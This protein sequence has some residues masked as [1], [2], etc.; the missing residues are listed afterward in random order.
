MSVARS[1]INIYFLSGKK[2][3]GACFGLHWLGGTDGAVGSLSSPHSLLDC[4]AVH[5]GAQGVGS[6]RGMVMC[7]ISAG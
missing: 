7:R 5:A 3:D 2:V 6:K 4:L 1:D